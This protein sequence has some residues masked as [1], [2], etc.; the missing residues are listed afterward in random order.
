MDDFDAT[1]TATEPCLALRITRTEDR[2]L[3]KSEAP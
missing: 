2:T 1:F 3:C